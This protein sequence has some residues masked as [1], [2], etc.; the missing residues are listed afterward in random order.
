[1]PPDKRHADAPREA[2][3]PAGDYGLPSP[4]RAPLAPA[5]ATSSAAAAGTAAHKD[6]ENDDYYDRKDDSG[7]NQRAAATPAPDS[8][9]PCLP[10]L[11]SPDSARSSGPCAAQ[12][13]GAISSFRQRLAETRAH[14]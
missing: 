9:R 4:H 14:Q 6:E 8:A 12:F 2:E 5:A 1:M 10:F 11:V 13:R 3:E 7:H